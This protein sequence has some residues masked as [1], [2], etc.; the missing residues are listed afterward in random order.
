MV[1]S[2]INYSY[3]SYIHQLSYLKRGPTLYT[4]FTSYQ[5]VWQGGLGGPPAAPGQVEIDSM[6]QE[7]QAGG[8][9]TGKGEGTFNRA[10]DYPLVI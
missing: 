6:H 7:Q 10:T 9:T 3:R 4:E 2:T 5:R 8:W 1:I